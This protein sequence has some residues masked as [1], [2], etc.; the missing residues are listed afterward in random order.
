MVF[1]T[2][3]T[4]P[5]LWVGAINCWGLSRKEGEAD[6][7]NLEDISSNCTTNWTDTHAE[8]E[9]R[10]FFR[11]YANQLVLPAVRPFSPHN[12]PVILVCPAISACCRNSFER[13]EQLWFPT[14]D[15]KRTDRSV[16]CRTKYQKVQRGKECTRD[17]LILVFE[18]IYLSWLRQS[19][20]RSFFINL[21]WGERLHVCTYGSVGVCPVSGL[22]T[23]DEKYCQKQNAW[24][25]ARVS[26]S[27]Q[28]TIWQSYWRGSTV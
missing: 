2:A 18:V 14:W 27:P 7:D 24:H 22:A 19:A 13:L 11:L 1:A 3:S 20:S 5:I 25:I 17:Y 23:N 6:E 15:G 9:I 10:S 12:R 16:V 21:Q 4:K 8:T 28:S 26:A